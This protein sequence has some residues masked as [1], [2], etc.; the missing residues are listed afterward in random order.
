MSRKQVWGNVR[1]EGTM[2]GQI[3]FRV[4][5]SQDTGS[6]SFGSRQKLAFSDHN[7][8]IPLVACPKGLE[9]RVP[10]TGTAHLLGHQH[11]HHKGKRF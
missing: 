4:I 6:Y 2:S 3:D 7:N 11:L 8:V 9:H 10:F 5:R 1:E